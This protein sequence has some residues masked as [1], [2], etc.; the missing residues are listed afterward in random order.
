ML[1]GISNATAVKGDLSCYLSSVP[2]NAI[3][4]NGQQINSTLS[5]LTC[6]DQQ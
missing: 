1:K 5:Q 6:L 2:N 4:R 3:I